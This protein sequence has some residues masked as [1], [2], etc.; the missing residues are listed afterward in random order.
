MQS[1]RTV[2][3]NSVLDELVSV[4]GTELRIS[5]HAQAAQ[6]C[7]VKLSQSI[8]NIEQSSE[9]HLDYCK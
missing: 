7:S 1:M 9:W 8:S 6:S 4:S 3:H 5:A 2:N